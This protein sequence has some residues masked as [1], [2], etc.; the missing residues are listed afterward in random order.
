MIVGVVVGDEADVRGFGFRSGRH[1]RGLVALAVLRRQRD[2]GPVG[3]E[4]EVGQG[5]EAWGVG[6]QVLERAV[7]E[8]EA[9]DVVTLAALVVAREVDGA[10][11]GREQGAETGVGHVYQMPRLGLAVAVDGVDLPVAVAIP[12]ERHRPAVGRHRE[13]PVVAFHARYR[14]KPFDELPTHVPSVKL[15][16][17]STGRVSH[18]RT[19]SERAAGH[20]A[21]PLPP[22]CA[23]RPPTT[24][25]PTCCS[26]WMTIAAAGERRRRAVPPQA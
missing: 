2:G 16:A 6:Q 26:G 24:R 10:A 12:D 17:R 9:V 21:P 20:Q 19:I 15:G 3:G 5:R 13:R 11:V 1:E 8:S 25:V 14:R 18:Q 7:D 22:P 23:C 4:G